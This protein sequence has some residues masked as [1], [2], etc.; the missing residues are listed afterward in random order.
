[1]ID[2][3]FNDTFPDKCYKHICIK[4]SV[5]FPV[6]CLA[7]VWLATDVLVIV[8]ADLETFNFLTNQLWM[9][10]L[11]ARAFA[12]VMWSLRM[13]SCRW[14]CQ[15]SDTYVYF[16]KLACWTWLALGAAQWAVMFTFW[17][18]IGI[19]YGPIDHFVDVKLYSP[20]KVML[21]NHLRHVS[22]VLIHTMITW[23]LRAWVHDFTRDSRAHVLGMPC[24]YVPLLASLMSSAHLMFFDDQ[25]LYH[26][27]HDSTP[28][29]CIGMFI[30]TNIVSGLYLLSIGQLALSSTKEISTSV[31]ANPY[32]LGPYDDEGIP[33]E[34]AHADEHAGLILHKA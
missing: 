28:K 8:N 13:C 29:W 33:S 4:T 5:H 12:I 14:I 9:F 20:R 32:T 10:G 21:W 27:V 24:L 26:Y 34:S 1:M 18:M 6:W 19:D 2:L 17:L 23:E 22:P 30:A 31:F 11:V 7:A 15:G 16:E 25:E 3:F